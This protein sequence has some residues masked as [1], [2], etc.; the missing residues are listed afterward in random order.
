MSD[1]LQPNVEVLR[2][3]ISSA[4]GELLLCSPYVSAPALNTVANALPS[5]VRTIEFWTKLN[6]SDWLTGA[7]DFESLLDFISQVEGE[8]D[9]VAVR[10]TNRL[11]AKMVM[12]G[13]PKAIAGS[14]NLTAG[15]FMRNLEVIRVVTGS[16]LDQLHQFAYDLRPHLSLIPQGE[17]EK[18]VSRCTTRIDDKEALLALIRDEFT[19]P[20]PPPTLLMPYRDFLDYLRLQPHSL[21]TEILRIA[22]NED[23]NNN[24]GKV[25]QAYF[26]VQRF[27]QEYPSHSPFVENLPI[28]EFEVMQSN[29]SSDWTH[30]LDQFASESN[31]SYEYSIATLRG[32]L[33]RNQGGDLVGGGGGSNQLKRVWPYAGRAVRTFASRTVIVDSSPRANTNTG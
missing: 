32:Y 23:G 22:T 31:P 16:E 13:G 30:F 28:E 33:P 24:T 17:L 21:A 15:G 1:W 4:E 14:A 6:A 25:K 8:V 12:S 18:F 29:L 3:V 2:E 10:H 7:T 26:G 5:A 27:L 11:H 20:N 19:S 9:G